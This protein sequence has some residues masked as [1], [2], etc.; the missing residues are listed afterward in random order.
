MC[1]YVLGTDADRQIDLMLLLGQASHALTTEL[2][3][4]LA[5]LGITPRGQCVLYHASQ[6]E[7]TQTQLAQLCALDK[8]TMVFAMDELE[9]A[10]LAERRLSATD[11]RARIIAVT[12]AGKEVVARAQ[13]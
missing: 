6:A 7:L 4:G 8:T 1:K 9:R 10:G 12:S 3:A 2:T 11:R 5:T 13:A